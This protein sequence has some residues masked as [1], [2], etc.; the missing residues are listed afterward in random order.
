LAWRIRE[1]CR[2]KWADLNG[3]AWKGKRVQEIE[4]PSVVYLI[5]ERG[6]ARRCQL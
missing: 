3:E 5:R 6:Q 2:G 1:V 4:K